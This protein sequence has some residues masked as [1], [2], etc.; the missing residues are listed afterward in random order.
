MIKRLK[1]ILVMAFVA[2]SV[3]AQDGIH[4]TGKT[5]SNVDYHHGQ[6][7]PA[8]GTHNIQTLRANREYPDKSD[9]LGWTYNH[10]PMLAYW[11]G[12]TL[13]LEVFVI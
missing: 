1:T 10:A 13:R 5:L 12:S 6:L 8:V 7:N 9:G 4:Y 2:L 3:S 11:N